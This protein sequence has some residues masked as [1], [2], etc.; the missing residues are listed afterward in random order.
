MILSLCNT[1]SPVSDLY[2]MTFTLGILAY[3]SD[4]S[5]ELSHSLL[6]IATH[7]SHASFREAARL[8]NGDFDLSPGHTLELKEL[9]SLVELRRSN[10]A[11]NSTGATSHILHCNMERLSE[12]LSIKD[13]RHI[14]WNARPSANHSLLFYFYF[15]RLHP[16]RCPRIYRP[17][18]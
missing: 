2:G 8:P 11:L 18:L 17:T 4:F 10:I 15:G 9:Q 5:R 1:S 16:V 13:R 6:A 14:D 3:C 12:P 7:N